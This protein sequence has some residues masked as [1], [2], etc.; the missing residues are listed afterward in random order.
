MQVPIEFFR[1][2][3]YLM[4]NILSISMDEALSKRISI[5]PKGERS[6]IICNI[7]HEYCDKLESEQ[8]SAKAKKIMFKKYYIPFIQK[9]AGDRD[10]FYLLN[11]EGLRTAFKEANIS[12]SESDIKLCIEQILFEGEE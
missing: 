4:S 1:S 8:N 7:I 2:Y 6:K 9:Y 11:N 12:I 5:I 10:P 3:T